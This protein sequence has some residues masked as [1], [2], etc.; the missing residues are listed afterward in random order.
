MTPG[1]LLA[2]LLGAGRKVCTAQDV[3]AVL[4]VSTTLVYDEVARGTFPLEPIRVGR[5]IRFRAAD[6]AALVGA[7]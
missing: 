6:L 5:L 7:A 3:A 2:E 4:E 1:D